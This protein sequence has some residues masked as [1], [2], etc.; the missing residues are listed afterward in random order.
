VPAVA[1]AAY[2][3]PN[4]VE[5]PSEWITKPPLRGGAHELEVDHKT[6]GGW[7]TVGVPLKLAREDG[8]RALQTFPSAR[9]QSRL[10]QPID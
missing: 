2:P 9:A 5:P 3:L 1:Q 6:A 4:L 8:M 7:I 10:P